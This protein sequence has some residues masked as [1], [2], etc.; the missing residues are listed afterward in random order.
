MGDRVT[1]DS[2]R[3][4][5]MVAT[6]REVWHA[7]PDLRLGQ[8]VTNAPYFEAD[9]RNSGWALPP[10]LVEDARMEEGLRGLLA[11]NAQRTCHE[12]YLNDADD[13]WEGKA[14][15][16]AMEADEEDRA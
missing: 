10:A 6:L 9:G 16:R 11:R 8:L 2:A 13:E 15:A 14:L 7:Y 4:D 1:R 3:I 12:R 5:R